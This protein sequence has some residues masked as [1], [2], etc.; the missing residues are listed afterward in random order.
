[1][2]W[3]KILFDQ[4]CITLSEICFCLA[5][6]CL[7]SLQWKCQTIML[8]LHE[9]TYCLMLRVSYMKYPQWYSIVMMGLSTSCI[10]K[11]F[12]MSAW[13]IQLCSTEEADNA[14]IM[15]E[16]GSQVM[17]N[18]MWHTRLEQSRCGTCCMF[19]SSWPDNVYVSLSTAVI[20]CLD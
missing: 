2:P 14:K 12:R 15:I 10:V 9:V 13:I 18:A 3:H 6:N 19:G 20:I 17:I 8:L 5:I 7:C 16:C 4:N 1:M 11:I